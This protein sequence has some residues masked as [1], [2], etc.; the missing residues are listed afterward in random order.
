MES[1]TLLETRSLTKSMGGR[2]IVDDLSLKVMKGDVYGFLGRNGQGK[3]TTIRLMTG[4]IFPDS[5]DVIIDGHNLRTEFKQA[6]S[7]VGAIVESPTFYEYLSGHENLSLMAN[8]V[9]GL[10][11][12]RVDDV[13]EIVR[14]KKRAKDKVKTYS[15]GMKQ[16]LGIAN[17]LLSDPKLI[18][19]DE[20]TNGLD[21]QGMKEIR[22]MIVQL[23]SEKDITFFISSHLLYEMQQL[24]NRIGIISEGKLLVEGNVSELVGDSKDNSLE[25][26]F[27]E[28]TGE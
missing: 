19:L 9:S 2:K 3:T 23:S 13:L 5:G 24:C 21:P 15:L 10:D 14:L 16:R 27:F 7:K 6:I 8:L 17:A 11:R 18:I 22:E 12:S 1:S 4:L 20:P 26:F 28:A 25:K